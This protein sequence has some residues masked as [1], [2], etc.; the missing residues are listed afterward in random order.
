MPI[1]IYIHIKENSKK[2]IL[3]RSPKQPE[4]TE[5]TVKKNPFKVTA[6]FLL[7]LNS[8]QCFGAYRDMIGSET[9]ICTDH[10]EQNNLH[11]ADTAFTQ[12]K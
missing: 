10:S 2:I 4:V 3:S 5:S 11:T 12:L 9:F 7:Y 1:Y 6:A 8:V